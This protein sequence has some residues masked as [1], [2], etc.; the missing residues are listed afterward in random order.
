MEWVEPKI[1][2][3]RKAIYVDGKN[4]NKMT[5]KQL[6][7]PLKMDVSE[8]ITRKESRHTIVEAG[9]K[10]M[11]DRFVKAWEEEKDKGETAVSYSDEEVKVVIDQ[12]PL[13]YPCH[14]VETSHPIETKEKYIFQRVKL[15]F[16]KSTGL[17]V[18]MEGYDWP[19]SSIPEGRLVEQYTYADLQTEPVPTDKDFN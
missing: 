3:G 2:K 12:K 4:N 15:Y 10:N 17:P 11:V 13:V 18:R 1:K 6:G 19:T 5:V 14:V 16:D 8:S 9:L 7:I